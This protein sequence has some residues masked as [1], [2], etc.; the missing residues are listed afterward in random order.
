MAVQAESQTTSYEAAYDDQRGY[1]WMVYAGV[2]LLVLGTLNFIEGVA[3]IDHAHF[4]VGNAHYIAGDLNTWGWVVMWIGVVQWI[5]GVGV[6]VKNQFARWSGVVV[7]SFNAIAQLVMIPAYPF[8]SLCI[9]AL[10]VV[11]IY[12]L[13]TYGSRLGED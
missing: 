4:F 10:D 7:L 6:F 8:W 5:V 9:L 3:A 2:L 13:I 12:G 1:G 11:A